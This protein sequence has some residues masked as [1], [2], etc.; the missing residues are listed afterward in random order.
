[1]FEKGIYLFTYDFK[2]AYHHICIREK[3]VNVSLVLPE[4]KDRKQTT[5]V[6]I[7]FLSE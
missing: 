3:K 4:Q 1:M 2:V 6:L 7:A 5:I